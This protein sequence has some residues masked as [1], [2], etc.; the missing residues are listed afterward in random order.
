MRRK[1]SM[2][3]HQAE[4]ATGTGRYRRQSDIQ[5]MLTMAHDIA[6]HPEPSDMEWERTAFDAEKARQRAAAAL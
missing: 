2:K 3:D 1:G 4:S 5:P 6:P